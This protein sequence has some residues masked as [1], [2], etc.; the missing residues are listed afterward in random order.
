MKY[1][2]VEMGKKVGNQRVNEYYRSKNK[3]SYNNYIK[4]IE[5]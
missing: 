2:S 4:M 5:N 3:Q 1:R